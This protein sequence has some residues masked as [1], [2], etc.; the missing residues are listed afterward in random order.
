MKTLLVIFLIA[1]LLV[2]GGL[3]ILD[4][5]FTLIGGLFG[6]IVGLIGMVV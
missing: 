3:G 6:L 2:A 5:A 4:L 1:F